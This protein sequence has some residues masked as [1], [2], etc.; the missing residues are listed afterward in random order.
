[1]EVIGTA[2]SRSRRKTGACL[3]RTEQPQILA[4]NNRHMHRLVDVLQSLDDRTLSQLGI[5]RGEI[6]R[7][8]YAEVAMCAARPATGCAS[9]I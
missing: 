8:A 1:M 9:Q 5:E 7:F 3:L 6:E 4:A 2:S